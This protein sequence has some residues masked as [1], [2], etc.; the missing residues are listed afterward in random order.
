MILLKSIRTSQAILDVSLEPL[1][2]RL[3]AITH[4]GM[5]HLYNTKTWGLFQSLY[6]PNIFKAQFS[7]CGLLFY[8]VTS[9]SHMYVWNAKSFVLLHSFRLPR[10][11]S[12]DISPGGQLL[13]FGGTKNIKRG[14]KSNITGVLSMY[15]GDLLYQSI[16][17]TKDVSGPIR[18]SNFGSKFAVCKEKSI[19][20]YQHES[21]TSK[22]VMT[23]V[24]KL[25]SHPVTFI[26]SSNDDS[27]LIGTKDYCSVYNIRENAEQALTTTD[28]PVRALYQHPTYPSLLA[29]ILDSGRLQFHDS[30]TMK[31][32]SSVNT[33][34]PITCGGFSPEGDQFILC[35]GHGLISVFTIGQNYILE[36]APLQQCFGSDY[37]TVSEIPQIGQGLLCDFSGVPLPSQ[38]G[39]LDLD[40]ECELLSFRA[41]TVMSHRSIE[42]ELIHQHTLVYEERVPRGTA[43]KPPPQI[44]RQLRSGSRSD[45]FRLL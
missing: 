24:V 45:F 36:R 9:N 22:W 34:L 30:Q 40:L 23:N 18:F 29:V 12:V 26:W 27:L 35:G 15:A 11:R 44:K 39:R 17:S 32:H 2:H 33:G 3:L 16:S 8:A 38:P 37:S 19:A 13:V 28:S 5:V 4:P 14:K 7:P 10:L 31:L 41:V 1:E 25:S 21:G 42:L 20:I 43:K 6:S